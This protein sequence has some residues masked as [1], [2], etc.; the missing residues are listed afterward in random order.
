MLM[1]PEY[2]EYASESIQLTPLPASLT[3]KLKSPLRLT[4]W[5]K[6]YWE[7]TTSRGLISQGTLLKGNFLLILSENIE[8][9]QEM[10]ITM[11]W[12]LQAHPTLLRL[13]KLPVVA[14]LDKLALTNSDTEKKA[15]EEILYEKL[16]DA[17]HYCS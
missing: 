1:A 8:G 6:R 14:E 5:Q 13:K 3:T 10:P 16:L 2:K 9:W 12:K 7:P 15:Q 17:E 11:L 4:K